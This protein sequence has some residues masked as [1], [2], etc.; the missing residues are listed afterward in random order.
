MERLPL[1]AVCEREGIAYETGRRWKSNAKEEGDDWDRARQASRMAQGGLGDL[2]TQVLEDFAALFLTTMEQLREDERITSTQ[3]AEALSR[4]SD[5]YTKTMKAAGG[6]DPKMAELSIAL[7]VLDE[8]G[9][10]IKH[11]HPDDLERFT[12]ILEPFGQRV[13]EVFA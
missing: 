12:R 11:H 5:A 9:R 10:F 8:L 4:M 6:A 1:N 2:T 13:S 7:K 3:R